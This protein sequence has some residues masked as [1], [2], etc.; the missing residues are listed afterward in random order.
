MFS[1]ADYEVLQWCDR[2]APEPHVLYLGSMKGCTREPAFLQALRAGTF[3]AL[4]LCGLPLLFITPQVNPGTVQ[5]FNCKYWCWVNNEH[6]NEI[7]MC[8][9]K[10]V[11]EGKSHLSSLCSPNDHQISPP[12][13]KV[14]QV[15]QMKQAVPKPHSNGSSE[16]VV[17]EMLD[18]PQSES[19]FCA[20]PFD[21]CLGGSLSCLCYCEKSLCTIPLIPLMEHISLLLVLD[22]FRVGCHYRHPSLM[23]SNSSMPSQVLTCLPCLSMRRWDCRWKATE[24]H[25]REL[26][27]GYNTWLHAQ[28]IVRL[29]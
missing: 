23:A 25:L 9:P 21:F 1:T 17:S 29:H 11:N 12:V 8:F 15:P 10:G 14:L 27:K 3:L 13:R 24:W 16:E 20:L 22:I 19:I 6:C 5:S 7:K 26:S 18:F 28:A 4:H 2:L